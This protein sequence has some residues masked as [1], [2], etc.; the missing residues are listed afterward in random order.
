MDL[1]AQRAGSG[2]GCPDKVGIQPASREAGI[3]R[4]AG[5]NSA[6]A[7]SKR[8]EGAEVRMGVVI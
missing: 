5:G 2:R 4:A 7:A 6:T 8:T 3:F 1:R